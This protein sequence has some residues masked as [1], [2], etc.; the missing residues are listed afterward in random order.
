MANYATLGDRAVAVIIDSVILFLV[1]LVFLI[2]LIFIPGIGF[3]AV[4]GLGFGLLFG[5]LVL[6]PWLLGLVYFTYF[7]STSGQTLGKGMV[8]IKVVDETSQRP[9]DMG[10]ALIRNILRIIDWLPFLYIVG[11]VLVESQPQ[12]K[13]LGDTVAKTIV[14]K[15]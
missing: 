14:V 13:R 11:L 2:P 12:K 5:P 7:E 4:F 8:G 1:S 6:A 15:A 3:F 9:V 10:R